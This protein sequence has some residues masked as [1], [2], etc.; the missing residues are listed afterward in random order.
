MPASSDRITDSSEPG[1]ILN[2]VG[3]LVALGP[4]RRDLLSLYQRWVNDFT[5]VRNLGIPPV[6]MSLEAETNWYDGITTAGNR[7]IPFTIYERVSLRPI[8]TMGLHAVDY[9]NRTAEFG[10]MIGEVDARGRGFGTEATRLMLDYAFTALG[11]NNVMLRV[12]D[13]NFAGLRAYQ[14]AGFREFGR[15]RESILTAG[16]LRDVIFMECLASEFISPVL[17]NIFAPDELRPIIDRDE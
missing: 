10:I 8:G 17:A 2:I 1:P 14:K 7:E 13:Y 16:T 3:D 9:R 12:F 5:A 4:M 11:L 6:P 15:R